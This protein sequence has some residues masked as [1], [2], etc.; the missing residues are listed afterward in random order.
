MI[1]IGTSLLP[2]MRVAL[3][4]DS[5]FQ[6]QFFTTVGLSIA[7]LMCGLTAMILMA[8]R[9]PNVVRYSSESADY[10]K[11]AK[12]HATGLLIFTGIPLANFL[13]CFFLWRRWRHESQF[14]DYQGR[15][16]LCFQ[17]SIYLYLLLCLF[18]V[19]AIIGVIATPVVLILHLVVTI[20]ATLRTRAGKAFRYPANITIIERTP[21][22]RIQ[23]Q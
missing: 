4:I 20:V 16:A 7:G 10:A 15:E 17:I 19:L 23:K 5:T 9:Q 14:L 12:L 18:M 13:G 3:G 1:C 8:R 22:T 6:L 21:H 11:A 2:I